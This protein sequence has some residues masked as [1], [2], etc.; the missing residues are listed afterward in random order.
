MQA[1]QTLTGEH[2]SHV[3]SVPGGTAAPCGVRS[4]WF[5]LPGKAEERA[6]SAQRSAHPSPPPYACA[7]PCDACTYLYYGHHQ[8]QRHHSA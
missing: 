2:R 5:A 8:A 7:A 6:R 1:V 4:P 3:T